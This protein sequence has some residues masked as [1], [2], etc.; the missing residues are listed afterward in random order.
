MRLSLAYLFLF[1]IA[2]TAAP[3]VT[4]VAYNSEATLLVAGTRG[5]VTLI[6]PNK[7]EIVAALPEQTQRV[8]ALAFSKANLLAVASGETGKSGIVKIYDAKVAKTPKLI[9]THPAHKDIVYSLAFDP[10]GQTL[11][12]T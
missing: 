11:A 2:A 7:G 12:T 10:S 3:P 4:V 6:E 1:S 8:T 5:T 9:A